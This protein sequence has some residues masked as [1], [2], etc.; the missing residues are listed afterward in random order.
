MKDAYI[1]KL[2][3][4]GILILFSSALVLALLWRSNQL[5]SIF[6]QGQQQ[7]NYYLRSKINEDFFHKPV[8]RLLTNIRDHSLLPVVKT[9]KSGAVYILKDSSVHL[10]PDWDSFVYLGYSQADIRVISEEDLASY[11][12]GKGVTLTRG[13]WESEPWVANFPKSFL[14]FHK[15][16]DQLFEWTNQSALPS[17]PALQPGNLIDVRLNPNRNNTFVQYTRQV[18]PTVDI[19]T[20]GE[21]IDAIEHFFWGMENGIAIELGALDGSPKTHSQTYHMETI[22]GWNRILIE[23]NPEYRSSM[24]T[25]SSGALGVISAICDKP[26]VMHYAR[27]I[28]GPYVGGLLEF[29]SADYMKRWHSDIYKA[30]ESEGNI[31]TLDFS[32]IS[33]ERL[34]PVDCLPLHHIFHRL[35]IRH[36]NLFILDVE[37]A[38]MSILTSINWKTTTFDVL[39][40]ETDDRAPGYNNTIAAYLD[41]FGYMPV[42]S[43]MRNTWFIRKTFT[44]S[45]RPGLDTE[46]YNG[47]N[48]AIYNGRWMEADGKI[49]NFVPCKLMGNFDY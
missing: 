36:I 10:I 19:Y 29:M 5:S 40:I 42:A 21:S 45:K 34:L 12:L 13:W 22:L 4:L 20:D 16:L 15:H 2:I 3:M 7:V 17:S 31:S 30:C 26:S 11:T 39:A 9:T 44:P 38:E 24:K 47:V 28:S 33:R 1:L 6:L 32:K 25:Q 23:A 46:C 41:K 27:G 49:E 43:K 37:G 18:M 8:S 35:H 48:H 14:V